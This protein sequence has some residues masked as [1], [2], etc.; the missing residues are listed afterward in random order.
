MKKEEN[1]VLKV[2]GVER[3]GMSSFAL[4]V[5]E[6]SKELNLDEIPGK[7]GVCANRDLQCHIC[8]DYSEYVFQKEE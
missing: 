2:E 7:C 4:K 8:L 5:F 6:L 1:I 3:Q